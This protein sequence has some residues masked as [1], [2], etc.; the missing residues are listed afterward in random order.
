MMNGGESAADLRIGDAV[1]VSSL[2][3]YHTAASHG[4]SGNNPVRLMNKSSIRQSLAVACRVRC[5]HEIRNRST[6]DL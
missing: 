6:V 5:D 4:F 1:L 3:A 2:A